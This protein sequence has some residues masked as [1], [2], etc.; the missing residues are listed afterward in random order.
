[1]V[2]LNVPETVSVFLKK[3]RYVLLVLA[4]GVFLMALPSGTKETD[5]PSQLPTQMQESMGAQ[6]EAIISCIDGA[7]KTKVLLTIQSG[8]QTIYQTDEDTANGESSASIHTDT[9]LVTDSTRSQS[10]LVRQVIAP[11]YQGAVIVCQ[12]GADARVRLAIVEAVSSVT[13]LGADKITV[14]KMKG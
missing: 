12:G 8:E 10:G 2:K 1:M 4:V 3:Y 13:G 7:G 6:L 9:V 5:E 11:K 14:L